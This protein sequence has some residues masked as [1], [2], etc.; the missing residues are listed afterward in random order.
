MAKNMLNDKVS[1]ET[2]IKYTR[3]TKEE[4]EALKD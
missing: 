2:I 4:I 3:L 1:I